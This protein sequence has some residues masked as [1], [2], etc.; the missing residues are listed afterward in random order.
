MKL[1]PE[2]EVPNS[3]PYELSGVLTPEQEQLFDTTWIEIMAILHSMKIRDEIYD[4]KE[5]FHS[6]Y[7]NRHVFPEDIAIAAFDCV[8]GHRAIKCHIPKERYAFPGSRFDENSWIKYLVTMYLVLKKDLFIMWIRYV[9]WVHCAT[10]HEIL[11]FKGPFADTCDPNCVE[12]IK[13]NFRDLLRQQPEVTKNL[14]TTVWNNHS[15]CFNTRITFLVNMCWWMLKVIVM[16]DMKKDLLHPDQSRR[17]LP[18]ESEGYEWLPSESWGAISGFLQQLLALGCNIPG[19][20]LTQLEFCID[21]VKSGSMA[22]TTALLKFK[23]PSTGILQL[24]PGI[25]NNYQD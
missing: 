9:D 20:C 2:P 4:W 24:F 17:R 14:S 10:S 12:S 18:V 7:P 16:V 21:K 1:P 5:L 13:T 22:A 3:V 23:G 19:V 6:H 15:I 11:G 8:V 25:E